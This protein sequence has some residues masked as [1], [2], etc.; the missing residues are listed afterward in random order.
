MFSDILKIVNNT[1]GDGDCCSHE[2]YIGDIKVEKYKNWTLET[3]SK[4]TCYMYD[5]YGKCCLCISLTPDMIT[6][7][8][9]NKFYKIIFFTF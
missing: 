2:T 4:V 1:L 8:I 9:K 3:T 7:C 5:R 6:K